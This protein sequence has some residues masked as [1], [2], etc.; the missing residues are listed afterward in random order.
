MTSPTQ[1]TARPAATSGAES[2]MAPPSAAPAVAL[3][4]AHAR[5]AG[6]SVWRDVSFTIGAGEFT[7]ILGPNGSGKTTLLR[8]LLGELA[9]AAGSASVLGRAPGAVSREIGYLPQRRHFDASIRI[10]GVDLVRLGLD[11]ARWGLPLRRLGRERMDE[12]IAVVGAE[13]YATRPSAASPA[14]SSSAC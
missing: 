2:Q 5:I 4:G 1:V 3:E 14:A 7:S 9:L 12:V 8:V 10:R 6:R 11:G 13:A